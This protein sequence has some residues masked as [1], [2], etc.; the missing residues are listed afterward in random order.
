MKNRCNKFR[1]NLLGQEHWIT[2]F[3]PYP[4]KK[5]EIYN[6]LQPLKEMRQMNILKKHRFEMLMML[7]LDWGLQI[8]DKY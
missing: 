2:R 6:N 5:L 4:T 8:N 7:G 1:Q 3:P